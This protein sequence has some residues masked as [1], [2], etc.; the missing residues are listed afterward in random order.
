MKKSIFLLSLTSIVLAI[1]CNKE[2]EEVVITDS[3]EST[4]QYAKEPIPWEPGMHRGWVEPA[5][6]FPDCTCLFAGSCANDIVLEGKVILHKDLTQLVGST[7][8]TVL[9]NFLKNNVVSIGLENMPS[10]VLADLDYAENV[11]LRMRKSEGKENFVFYTNV[12]NKTQEVLLVLPFI[13]K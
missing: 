3:N 9:V 4:S 13:T 8:K 7:D 2:S 5:V 11:N 12:D 1:S 10:N 6:G